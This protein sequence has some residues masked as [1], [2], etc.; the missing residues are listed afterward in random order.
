MGNRHDGDTVE[1]L[2]M[3]IVWAVVL[4]FFLLSKGANASD[5]WFCTERTVVR[6]GNTYKSC[7]VASSREEPTARLKSLAAAKREF[8]SVCDASDDCRDHEVTVETGRTECTKRLIWWTCRRL[9]VFHVL[10]AK[11]SRFQEQSQFHYHPNYYMYMR[12]I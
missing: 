2:A 4:V 1:V 5:D 9:L 10:K 8:V 12:N 7:G 11:S 3:L 6:E